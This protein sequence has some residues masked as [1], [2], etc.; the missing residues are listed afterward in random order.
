MTDAV[1]D[2]LGDDEH[3]VAEDLAE[4]A[5]EPG[6]RIAGQLRG[7]RLGRELECDEWFD[8]VHPAVPE[9]T[10]ASSGRQSA[11]E[12]LRAASRHTSSPAAGE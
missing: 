10:D 1:R 5:V 7:M 6:D 3:D 9:P 4:V 12:R 11:A 8:P 2:E